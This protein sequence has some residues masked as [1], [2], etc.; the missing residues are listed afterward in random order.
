MIVPNYLT[1]IAPPNEYPF[2]S[3]NELSIE[4]AN[5]IKEKHCKRNN[6]RYFYAEN[7]YL[8]HRME[9]EQWLY[10]SLKEKGGNPQNTVPVYMILGEPKEGETD[11]RLDIQKNGIE[12]RIDIN[13]LDIS[14]ISFTYP[15]SMYELEYDK[16]GHIIGGKRTNTPKVYLFN[17]L[18]EL[19]IQKKVF[20]FEFYI[21]AQVWDKDKLQ[22]IWNGKR[23]KV[24]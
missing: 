10:N 13:E 9:I 22:K 6:I 17:E 7:E 18:E 4:K 12:Y 16:E 1:R 14:T 24:I 3:L 20:N 23:Y 15:D 11:I 19:I 2:V 5:R 21:E 8:L